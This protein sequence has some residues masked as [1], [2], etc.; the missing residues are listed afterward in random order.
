MKRDQA[1]VLGLAVLSAVAAR[2]IAHVALADI[3]H[4]MDEITYL[5]QAKVFAMGRVT[6]PVELPRGAFNMWFVEDRTSRFGIFPPGWPAA[7]AIAV[8]LGLERWLAPALHGVTIV[9]VG[10]AGGKLGGSRVALLAA[11]VYATSPQTVLMAAS[12]MSHTLVALAASIVMLFAVSLVQR[13]DVSLAL[14]VGTGAAVGITAAT[15]PLCAVILTIALAAATA[16]FARDRIRL[17]VRPFVIAAFAAMPFVIGL[18]LF[19]RATTGAAL[20][21]PQTTYFDEHLPPGNLPFFN[22]RKGCNAL[23]FGSGHGCDF[24]AAG[25]AHSLKSA[26]SNLGDNLLSW[27]RLLGGPLLLFGPLVAIVRPSTRRV[28]TLLLGVPALAFVAYSFYWHPGTCFGARFYQAAVPAAVLLIALGM[29][30][31]DK[32]V[33]VALA[34]VILAWHGFAFQRSMRELTDREWGYWGIDDRFAKA[35]KEWSKGPAVIMVAFG[36]DDVHN[37]EVVYTSKLPTGGMW[38]INI[39]A[40]APLAQ[41]EAIVDDGPLVFTKFHPALVGDIQARFPDRSL[42]LYVANGD[43]ALDR[44]EPWSEAAIRFAGTEYRRPADNFDGFRV[45]PPKLEQPA[46]FVPAPDP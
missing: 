33:V 15:R 41:N 43:R 7:L 44:L 36:G 13:S 24:T 32:R 6:A 42:W 25:S 1:I 8:R 22:Y 21:F 37:P 10:R 18:L 27:F 31:A 28:G 3:A 9:V 45:E 38:M 40:L 34:T 12:L 17:L 23:G 2:V 39:R 26:L 19:N 5:F 20:T 46:I 14:A 11:L 29:Q 30:A 35:K 16:L 4:V